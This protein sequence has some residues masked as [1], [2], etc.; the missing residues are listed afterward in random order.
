MSTSDIDENNYLDFDKEIRGQKYCCL[1]FLSPED[2]IKKKEVYFFESFMKFFSHEMCTLMDNLKEKFPDEEGCVQGIRDRYEYIFDKSRLM[3]EYSFYVKTNS[4]KLENE[5][6]VE[7]NFQTTMR[8]IKLRGSYETIEE[9]K[10]QA[11]RLSQVDKLFNV[12]VAQ[13]GCWCP[14]D[15]NP[16]NIDNVEYANAQLNTLMKKY[17]E[18]QQKKDEYFELR[19]LDMMKRSVPETIMEDAEPSHRQ[20]DQEQEV[21]EAS[22]SHQ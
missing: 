1:S 18:E 6:L 16:E 12:Y 15:P 22:S 2:V 8:G 9:A 19:K 3:D 21:G 17:K 20:Q 5:Y 4:D 10:Q 7:N 13:V 14:W 11:A